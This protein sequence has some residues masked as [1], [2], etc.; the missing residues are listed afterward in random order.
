MP[1]NSSGVVG[2]ISWHKANYED[3][4]PVPLLAPSVKS[5]CMANLKRTG[6]EHHILWLFSASRGLDVALTYTEARQASSCPRKQ[7]MQNATPTSHPWGEVNDCSN[8]IN[9]YL[10]LAS[11][12][13]SCFTTW[14]LDLEF[15]NGTWPAIAVWLIPFSRLSKD[16]L[17]AGKVFWWALYLAWHEW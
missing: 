15:C 14:R 8:P 9:V 6:W 3:D 4:L 12:L 5:V 1:W 11:Y 7:W 13:T 16:S 17:E 2:L 10:T